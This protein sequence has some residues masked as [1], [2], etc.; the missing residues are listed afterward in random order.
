MVN[1]YI[2]LVG[3]E[4]VIRQLA[5]EELPDGVKLGRRQPADG[6]ADAANAPLGPDEIRQLLELVSVAISTGTAAVVLFEKLR[7]L[8]K[9]GQQVTVKDARNGQ[10][11]ATVS[12][13]TP[14]QQVAAKVV[15]D[16]GAGT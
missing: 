14:A 10:T 8:L 11:L 5:R 9:P 2:T 6:F 7:A 3:P 1:S 4:E 13:S 15:P 12:P 16:D